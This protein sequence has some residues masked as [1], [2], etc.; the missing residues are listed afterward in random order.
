MCV[1]VCVCVCVC[2]YPNCTSFWFEPLRYYDT[3]RQR[4][5][6]RAL[7]CCISFLRENATARKQGTC[8]YAY[9]CIYK[10]ISELHFL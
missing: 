8:I 2:I 4:I 7:V 6:L 9:L 5:L 3:T 10:Y 1:C